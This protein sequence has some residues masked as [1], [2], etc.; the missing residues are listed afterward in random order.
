MH[1]SFS[2][3]QLIVTPVTQHQRKAARIPLRTLHF[4]LSSPSFF[5]ELIK[6][7]K[8]HSCKIQQKCLIFNWSK[9]V[10][11]SVF[12]KNAKVPMLM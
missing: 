12:K 1:A 5:K 7:T 8:T 3:I 11:F 2:M 6:N 9:D 10:H 4:V